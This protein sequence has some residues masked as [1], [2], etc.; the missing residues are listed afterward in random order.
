M[1]VPGVPIL[2]GTL[3]RKENYEDDLQVPT[4][5]EGTLRFKIEFGVRI[6]IRDQIRVRVRIKD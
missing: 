6:R 2:M 5:Q 3:F 1:S 4:E